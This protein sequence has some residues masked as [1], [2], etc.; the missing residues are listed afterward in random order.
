MR[1]LDKLNLGCGQEHKPGYVN[2]DWDP[3]IKTDVSHNLN[4]FPYPF[5]DETFTLV[6]A[7]HILEHLD[8]PFDVMRELHRILVPGGVLHI[9]VPH[10]SRGFTHAEH[11]HGFDVTFPMYFN[12]EFLG[13]GYTGI[14]F[15]LESMRF[16][17]SAFSYLLPN[18]GYGKI[19]SSGIKVLDTIFTF[20]ANLNP[21]L[22]SRLWC[23]WVGGFEELEFTFR[24]PL[25]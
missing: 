3:L 14:D 4:K 9:R 8:R 13:S 5:K 22:C 1:M 16:R 11:A 15:Q 17:W 18:L 2:I 6:E 7:F 12:K 10:C 24:K 19:A 21:H 25:K 23:Y 20:S